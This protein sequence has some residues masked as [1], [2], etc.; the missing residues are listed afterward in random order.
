MIVAYNC[1]WITI[2]ILKNNDCES[3]KGNKSPILVILGSLNKYTVI[4]LDFKC[5]FHYFIVTK[6]KAYKNIY[7]GLVVKIIF[8]DLHQMWVIPL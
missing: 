8:Y 3:N 2:K 5:D 6:I 1:N 7:E 4:W